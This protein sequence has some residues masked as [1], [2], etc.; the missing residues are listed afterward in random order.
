MNVI[1]Y[2]NERVSL[3]GLSIE[4][5]VSLQKDYLLKYLKEQNFRIE[6]LNPYQLNSFYTIPH[7]LLY[8][9]KEDGGHHDCLLV[10]SMEVLDN[11]ISAYP[12]KWLILKSFFNCIVEAESS[13]LH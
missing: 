13:V 12:G 6:C 7:A 2:V 10:Y 11:F 5:S 8:D 3:N 1:Y 4:E 9:L